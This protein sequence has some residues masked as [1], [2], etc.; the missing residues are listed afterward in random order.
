[1]FEERILL[2]DDEPNVLAAM[3]RRL[4]GRFSI[5]TLS[6][7]LK[8][9]EAVQSKGPYGVVVSDLRMPEMNGTELLKK[10]RELAPDTVRIMLTGYADVDTAIEA[11]NE[12]NVFRFLT[13]PCPAEV[14]E[15]ALG[16]GLK[17]YRLVRAERELL[18]QTLKG[19][20]RV[21][22]ELL[23]LLQP[24][25]FER[26]SRVARLAV[27]V[28]RAMDLDQVWKMETAALLSQIGWVT[29]P[30][31]LL[32]KLKVELELTPEEQ[33]L[34][35]RHPFVASN[36]IGHIPRL[37][38]IAEIIS[39]Q[40]KRFDGSGFPEGPLIGEDIPVE[41]RILKV[42]LDF[43][44]LTQKGKSREEALETLRSR[45][46]WYD[47]TVLTALDAVLNAATR[48]VV[49]ALGVAEIMPGMI[50]GEDV[51]SKEGTLLLAK[52]R[53]VTQPIL[54]RLSAVARAYGLEEP[55]RVLVPMEWVL[56]GMPVV[57]KSAQPS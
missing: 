25:A 33:R 30:E 42:L 28:A 17:Q 49:K 3:E 11:V 52:G 32:G 27:L 12:G 34:F 43:D 39:L 51:R 13:K 57:S 36:L 31:E 8:A 24:E 53:Q 18:E 16:A 50:I 21:L 44:F 2:V 10:I 14:L 37:G 6:H 4:K 15:R 38:E 56:R 48:Y 19:S 20:I 1:M 40:E 55:L 54:E 46:G 22:T 45:S 41:A 23:S 35:E 26:S 5:E 47:P 7:P 9:L 29:L